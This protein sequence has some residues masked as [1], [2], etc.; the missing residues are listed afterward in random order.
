MVTTAMRDVIRCWLDKLQASL[1]WIS[2][3]K[4]QEF[5]LFL[6]S[7]MMI[8]I[9]GAVVICRYVLRVDLFGYDE[10]VMISAFWMYFIGSSY[11]MEKRGHVRAD[12]LERV[13][14]PK[15]KKI[16]RILAGLLQSVVAIE[17]VNLSVAYIVNGFKIWPTTS[18]WGLPLMTSMSAVAVGLVLMA[19]Y[20]IVQLLEEITTPVPDSA[21]E[22]GEL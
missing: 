5:I 9:L 6:T 7:C 22:K 8:G 10:I 14:P 13:L 16:L 17:T 3:L 11:A 12:I 4:I 2:L 20:V 1:F 15:G 18:A 19:F 21:A